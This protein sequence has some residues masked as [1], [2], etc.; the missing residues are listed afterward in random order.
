[1]KVEKQLSDAGPIKVLALNYIMKIVD[2]NCR[3]QIK[4]YNLC[5]DVLYKMLDAA[6]AEGIHT[7]ITEY[8]N[9]NFKLMET[10][11]S[12]QHIK[13][14]HDMLPEQ[15][16]IKEALENIRQDNK[17]RREYYETEDI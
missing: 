1:M 17:K 2:P 13:E 16:R 9:I 7:A 12:T 11:T 5:R 10:S 3:M 6:Y 8:R 15:R 4:K 14:A